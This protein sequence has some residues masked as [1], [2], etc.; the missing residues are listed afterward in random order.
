MPVPVL[1]LAWGKKFLLRNWRCACMYMCGLGFWRG[2]L[3]HSP[4]ISL[5]LGKREIPMCPHPFPPQGSLL[6]DLAQS[7]LC[8][9][10]SAA[11]FPH[12][13]CPNPCL[14]PSAIWLN[15]TQTS[16]PYFM[17]VQS[18]FLVCGSVPPPLEGWVSFAPGHLPHWTQILPLQPPMTCYSTSLCL[19]YLVCKWVYKLPSS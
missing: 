7:R 11:R 18:W 2:E 9:Q 1:Y 10:M 13:P 15:L 8:N 5:D 17:T 6:K 4:H 19:S 14:H 12:Y 16:I 3:P